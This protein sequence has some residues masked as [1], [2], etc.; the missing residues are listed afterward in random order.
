MLENKLSQDFPIPNNHP[1]K[2]SVLLLL[3]ASQKFAIPSAG[4]NSLKPHS[5]QLPAIGRYSVGLV[6]ESVGF[7]WRGFESVDFVCWAF[8][9]AVGLKCCQL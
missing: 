4:I 9:S 8:E 3:R 7:V 1:T 2:F 5:L 6:C